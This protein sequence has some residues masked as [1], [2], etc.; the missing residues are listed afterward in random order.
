MASRSEEKDSRVKGMMDGLK[1][2]KGKFK[3][4]TIDAADNGYSV[5]T[6]RE[7]PPKAANDNDGDEGS[8]GA[9]N[10]GGMVAPTLDSGMS[11]TVHPDA[12]SVV[13]HVQKHLGK[14]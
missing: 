9:A 13:A 6:H 2:P 10:N 5:R 1:A 11:N 12:E 8:K 4:M 7:M 14:Y 3:S